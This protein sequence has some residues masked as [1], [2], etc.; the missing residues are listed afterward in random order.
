MW[1]K[2]D[3][4]MDSKKNGLSRRDLLKGM[5]LGTGAIALGGITP[6]VAE[7]AKMPKKW[8]LETDVIVVGYG[9]AGVAAAITAHDAGAKVLMLEKAPEKFKGGN[10][11]VSGNLTL[12][13]NNVGKA[14]TYFKAMS[15]PYQDN[16]SDEMWKAFTT[17]MVN[18]TA[19][20][21][22]LGAELVAFDLL[23][24]PD[25]PGSDSVVTYTH[26][27]GPLG[28]AR[29]WDQ[30]LEP[31]VAS[32]KIKVLYETPARRLVKKDS[33]IVGVVAEQKGKKI[34]IKAKRGVILTCGGFEN[35]QT[36]VRNYLPD[37]PYCYPMGTPYNEGD[38][39][40]MAME[41][42][43]DL[44]HMNNIAG[45]YFYFKVPEINVSSRIRVQGKSYIFVARDASR[46]VAEAPTLIIEDGRQVYPEK[47]GKVYRH[48]RYVQNPTPVPIHI[49]FDETVRKAGGLCG[50]AAGWT[51]SW[52][53]IFGDLYQWSKDN[54]R[55]IEKG[56][57]K[58]AANIKDLAKAV[59]LSPDAL[60]ATVNRYNKF[61]QDGVDLDFNRRKA[62]MAPIQ[63]PPF[64]I[65]ELTPTFINT[66]GGPRR[67]KEAQIMD[68]N[69]QPIPR[70]YSAGE[71][72]SIWGFQYQ[73]GGNVGECFAFGR[74]A[75]HNAAKLKPWK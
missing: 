13:P 61:C 60:D 41:V 35:N 43:A 29:L 28:Q 72:G 8:D 23:E 21:K 58:K 6:K 24:F 65:M 70:L 4:I 69:N 34:H 5:A 33:D 49:V 2:G 9:G 62:S 63:T 50:K 11:R 44:W 66:Q 20:L 73:G 15:G 36:M 22:G 7:A 27:K 45:P 46:F 64:Y 68:V 17:E 47:H 31:A 26:K 18:N 38:G 71:L 51:W 12:C 14:I 52:D 59:K 30:V 16:I 55:E 1:M 37:M 67:N 48:G 10:T 32:R 56:W 75:G 19:W 42:G 53:V 25:L 3:S 40:T 39:I 57:I 74:I 54:N